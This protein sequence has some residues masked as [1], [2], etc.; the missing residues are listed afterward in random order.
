[1]CSSSL[2]IDGERYLPW[3]PL[4]R[5]GV[6]HYE[7]LGRYHF[8]K[9]AAAGR[10]I[11]D[12]ASGEGYGSHM[13]AEVAEEVIGID[14][15]ADAVENA[16]NKYKKENL[17]FMQGDGCKVPIS[18]E[19]VFDIICSFE[20]IE[21]VN[22]NEQ[23]LMLKEFSRLVKDDG[24]LFI[25][26]PNYEYT[27]GILGF[28]NPHHKKELTFE[29]FDSLLANDFPYR[30]FFGQN[31]YYHNQITQLGTNCGLYRETI[32]KH[33]KD[34]FIE[35]SADKKIPI[36]YLCVASKKEIKFDFSASYTYDVNN[37]VLAEM[38]EPTNQAQLFWST[39]EDYSEENSFIKKIG[40]FDDGLIEITFE[41]GNIRVRNLRFD[42]LNGS[43][44]LIL[45]KAV[46][47]YD[48]G[49]QEEIKVSRSNSLYSEG[50]KYSFSS[51]IDP[52]L[53]FNVN[54][55]KQISEVRFEVEFLITNDAAKMTEDITIAIEKE[56]ALKRE[57]KQKYESVIESTSWKITK[58]L[59][60]LKQLSMK[61][62]G[63]V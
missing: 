21:H 63:Q 9:Q 53:Y 29:E 61:N 33:E 25:S 28:D 46:A 54:P 31:N 13:L 59:R 57:L 1:M 4:A 22:E 49:A 27:H 18:G 30:V 2:K 43:C 52:Q 34:A 32:L 42:P 12:L 56:R 16:K 3:M 8:L 50:S 39:D 51:T 44:I 20:T 6:S 62:E 15:A 19:K 60:K 26:T 7:H 47:V 17:K 40:S 41:T 55:N 24:L 23:V 36:L 37:T 45:R 5:W 14:I 35:T 10:Y 58:P 11:L 38:L 48:D